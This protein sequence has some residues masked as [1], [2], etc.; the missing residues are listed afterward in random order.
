MEQKPHLTKQ[1][2]SLLLEKNG[3]NLDKKVSLMLKKGELLPLKRGLYATPEFV[4]YH[5]ENVGDYIANILYYPSY[6]SLEYVLNKENLL[7]EAVYSYTSICLKPP[8]T[9]SNSLGVFIYQNIKQKL[10]CGFDQTSFFGTYK[11]K[12]ASKA[13]AL[14]DYF[15]LYPFG[16]SF[17]PEIGD[18]RINW[19][20]FNQRDYREFLK[21]AKLSNSKKMFAI[22]DIIKQYLWLLMI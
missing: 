20:N 6:L 5:Q 10:F 8:R 14:F 16:S 15:Y 22:S 7:P 1:D 21:Y 2:L 12:V 11:I 4:H 3:R 13:K 17:E 9:F 18:L 19:G